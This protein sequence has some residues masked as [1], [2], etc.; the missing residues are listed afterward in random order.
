MSNLET[1][2][3]ERTNA[4]SKLSMQLLKENE[5][6]RK[7]MQSVL[8]NS[9]NKEF[10]NNE[11]KPIEKNPIPVKKKR[12]PTQINFDFLDKES[13]ESNN[14]SEETIVILCLIRIMK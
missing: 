2:D 4:I 11:N 1:E 7:G 9:L 3:I 8:G 14:K 13:L 12:N 10:L 5:Y 6:L